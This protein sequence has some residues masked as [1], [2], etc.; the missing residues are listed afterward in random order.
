MS[1]QVTPIGN[2]ITFAETGLYLTTMHQSIIL[3]MVSYYNHSVFEFT[4]NFFTIRNPVEFS[5]D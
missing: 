1:S 5:V 4:A 3:K 2:S